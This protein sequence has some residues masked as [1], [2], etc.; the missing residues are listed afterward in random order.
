[1][2]IKQE[3]AED[4]ELVLGNNWM[5]F[6]DAFFSFLEDVT[7]RASSFEDNICAVWTVALF[8]STFLC[9]L[10]FDGLDFAHS[11]SE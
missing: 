10:V 5:L 3:R 4:E 7:M 8:L 9:L 11:L 2:P 1:M 6:C